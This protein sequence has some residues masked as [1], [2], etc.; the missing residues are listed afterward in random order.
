[1]SRPL[2]L[3]HSGAIWHVTS[4]GNERR[5]IYRDDHDRRFFVE[6]LGEVVRLNRWVLHAYVLMSN[7][8]HLL[9][10]TPLPTLSS[11]VKRL[12]EVY[13]GRFNLVHRRVGHLFQGRFKGILIERESHLLELVRYIVLNP[14][15]CGAVEFAGDYRWSNYRATA[16]IAAKPE[17]LEIDRTL[18]QFSFG[19]TAE[20]HETYRRFV[21]DARGADYKPWEA[22]IGQIYLGG[23]N[24][25]DR[26]QK[27]V[28]ISPRSREHPKPQRNFVRPSF[29][30][31]LEAVCETFE[32]TPDSIRHR[33]HRASRKAL[34]QIA[35]QLC[36]M[37]LA[38]LGEWLGLTDRAVSYLVQ[39]GLLLETKDPAYAARI[40][41]IRAIV[42]ACDMPVS[43]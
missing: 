30:L 36:G 10:E 8:Y 28:D 38:A 12:N 40:R 13:A 21:A 1:M 5:D 20:Q 39:C 23:E 43:S 17:W 25:C 9:V 33:S 41:R 29:E 24:F 3:E 7:H 4:R 14:V 32:E 22:L 34:A 37:T 27:L 26:M 11:G 35:W 2:R 31:I 15:R 42:E 16:G 6:L 18:S 19:S